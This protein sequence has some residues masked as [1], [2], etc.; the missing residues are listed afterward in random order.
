VA[1]SHRLAAWLAPVLIFLLALAVRLSFW[2]EIRGGALDRWHLWSQTDMATYLEQARRLKEDWLAREP[3]H[4]YHGWQAG[5]AEERWLSWYGPHAFH[6]APAYAYLLALGQR[7]RAD[8]LPIFKLVQLV[9]GALSC[10]LV[11]LIARSAAGTLAGSAAGIAAALYAPLLYLEPQILREAFAIAGLLAIL[12]ALV[13]CVRG[14][15]RLGA[16]AF[17]LGIGC[18]L[19][20]MLHEMG[21][22]LTAIAL[23]GLLLCAPV[24]PPHATAHAT[25]R[26]RAAALFLAGGLLGFAPLLARNLATGASPLSMSC[27]T[28]VNFVEANE[29]TAPGGGAEF[30]APTPTAM[31]ILDRAQGRFSRAL[32]L[33]LASYE[34]DARKLLGNWWKRFE[35]IWQRGEVPDNTSFAFYREMT[36]TLRPLPDFRWIFP[37]GFAGALFTLGRAL[38]ARASPG[39]VQ[40]ALWL[41]VL[42]ATASLSL[43]HTVARFRLFVVPFFLVQAGVAVSA[44]V[45][46]LRRRALLELAA[47]LG[48][49]ALG[50]FLQK[51]AS[52][53]GEWSIPRRDD[54]KTAGELALQGNEVDLAL[55]VAEKA[56]RSHP[57]DPGPYERVAQHFERAGDLE[58][59]VKH[60]RRAYQINPLP[61]I[62]KAL[63]SVLRRYTG[64]AS[65]RGDP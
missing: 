11:F 36:S 27:R 44:L 16:A 47:L 52:S 14:E 9:V 5:A 3:Y 43:V 7:F 23:L 54:Y 30:A 29:A 59:A 17:G 33:V 15:I 8:P 20:A 60:Y 58:Q 41:Y 28:T 6:Q 12:L 65:S 63:E 34:G 10:V 21:S 57:S 55:F 51:Q 18:G 53:R 49:L 22:V 61:R 48:L 24:P 13:R 56:V 46:S 42:A 40:A 62:S 4:P 50:W 31:E 19:Y 45:Q 25:G 26:A 64:A 2:G 1:R 39:R 35:I 38:L 32:P 37:L